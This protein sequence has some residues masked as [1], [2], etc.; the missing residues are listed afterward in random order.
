MSESGSQNPHIGLSRRQRRELLDALSAPAPQ[1]S[2]ITGVPAMTPPPAPTPRPVAS[3]AP[4]DAPTVL[5]VCTGNICRSPMAEA[6]LR[7]RLSDL[8]VSVHSAGTHALVD[9]EM[10]EPAQ[11]L[12]VGLGAAPVDAGAHRARLLVEPLLRDSD[13]VLAMA[14]EH[15]THTVQ[16]MPNVLRRVFTIREF[17]R[18]ASTLSSDDA[19]AAANAAGDSPRERLR[20]VVNAV[21]AQRGMTPTGSPEDDDVIDPYRRSQKTYDLSA[22]QLAPALDEVAR[23]LRAGLS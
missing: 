19:R 11:V 1:D 23:V 4:A 7:A 6:L 10:T 3:E 20:A 22:S 5:M 13:L 15:R 12:A 21:G 16:L 9:H 2:L 14:R 18:L 17:A 8:G